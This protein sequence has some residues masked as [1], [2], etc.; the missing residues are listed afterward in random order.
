MAVV[1]EHLL[2]VEPM[3]VMVDQKVMKQPMDV[4]SIFV[5]LLLFVATYKELMA[6]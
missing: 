3:M 1:P 5:F 4:E 2:D 6:Y